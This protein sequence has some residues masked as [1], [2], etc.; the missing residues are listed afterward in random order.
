MPFLPIDALH[1][2]K[3]NRASKASMQGKGQVC[4]LPDTLTSQ[5]K[6]WLGRVADLL[7]TTPGHLLETRLVD[8]YDL[9]ELPGTNPLLAAN[10]IRST[11]PAATYRPWCE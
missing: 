10:L 1:A 2:L 8:R 3:N 11:W 7:N 6:A 5:Q 9:Q 4:S